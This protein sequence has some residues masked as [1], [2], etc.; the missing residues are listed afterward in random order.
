VKLYHLVVR[1]D[2]FPSPHMFFGPGRDVAFGDWKGEDE[3]C[4]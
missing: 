1:E 2:F 4:A 3:S